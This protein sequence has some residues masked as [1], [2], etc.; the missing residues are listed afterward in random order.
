VR[1]FGDEGLKEGIDRLAILPVWFR[2]IIGIT[3]GVVEET[4]YRG[5]AIERLATFTGRVWLGGI[6]S[7][8]AFG[9]AHIPAWGVGF[10]IG[11]DLPFGIL[12]TVLYLWGRNLTV[13]IAAHSALLVI[14]LVSVP[15]NR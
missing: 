12:M 9:L 4:L 13:N 5:Y 2:V 7:V 15:T 11:A 10:A 8:I 1:I 14:A 6:I 3:A